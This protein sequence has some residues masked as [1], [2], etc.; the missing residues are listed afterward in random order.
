LPES[1]VIADV[2]KNAD[3]IWIWEGFR[4]LISPES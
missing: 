3:M 1:A 4:V 2:A